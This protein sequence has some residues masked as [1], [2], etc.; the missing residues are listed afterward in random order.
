MHRA[1][2]ALRGLDRCG[3]RRRALRVPKHQPAV[4]AGASKQ[5]ALWCKHD[6][7]GV[8]AVVPE[9]VR[10]DLCCPGA[11]AA[12]RPHLHRAV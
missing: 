12:H 2:L 10:L 1:H 7:L 8:V 5:A 4:E 6:G 11:V 9:R 3:D